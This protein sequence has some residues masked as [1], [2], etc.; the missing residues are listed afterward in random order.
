MHNT[1]T[2][3][4]MVRTLYRNQPQHRDSNTAVGNGTARQ[5]GGDEMVGGTRRQQK[6]RM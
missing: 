1:Q 2:G 5:T 4:H 6:D 3:Q